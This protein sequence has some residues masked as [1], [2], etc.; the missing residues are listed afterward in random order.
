MKKFNLTI[1]SNRL[2][3]NNQSE[4]KRVIVKFPDLFMI[5]TTMKDTEIKIQLKPGHYPVNR[6]QDQFHYTYK[7][8]SV[9]SWRN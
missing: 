1:K 9:E 8:K 4:K 5:N 7:T 2:D 3:E 6:K